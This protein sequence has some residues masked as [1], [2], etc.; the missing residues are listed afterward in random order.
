MVADN[1]NEY[2]DPAMKDAR[3]SNLQPNANFN[4]KT[5]WWLH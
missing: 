3:T 4:Y 2:Y 5:N 1:I